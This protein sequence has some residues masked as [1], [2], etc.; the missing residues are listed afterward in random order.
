MRFYPDLPVPLTLIVAEDDGTV[1]AR[2]SRSAAEKV[3]GTKLVSFPKGG[4]LLHEV[5]VADTAAAIL[6]AIESD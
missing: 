1:P 3:P 6:A 2:V 5:L 4:H